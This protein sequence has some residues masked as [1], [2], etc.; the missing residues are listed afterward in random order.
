[1]PIAHIGA[2]LPF[3]MENTMISR[4]LLVP[5]CAI[6]AI[7]VGCS[8]NP[9]D[10]DSGPHDASMDT[11]AKDS[12]GD[13]GKDSGKDASSD[14]KN[15]V[16]DA[17]DNDVGDADGDA[18]DG[19]IIVD[20]GGP[21]A[22]DGGPPL[23]KVNFGF[24]TVS[25]NGCSSGENWTCGND[26]YEVEC[27]C[28]GADCTCTKNNMGVGKVNVINGCPNCNFT[29]KTAAQLCGFPY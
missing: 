2:A 7:F 17:N 11:A 4:L 21:D 29:A 5:L 23:C 12:G 3:T 26:T 22:S 16:T 8:S 24:G 20:A 15:D 9:T 19:S 13:A 25:M 14:A 18:D 27:F 10:P 1:M 6:A 28:P